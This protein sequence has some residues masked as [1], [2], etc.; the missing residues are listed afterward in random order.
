[1]GKQADLTGQRFGRLI[2]LRQN[3]IDKH[4]NYLWECKC[5][6]GEITYASGTSL[7]RGHKR[8]CGC[9]M[10]DEC[11]NRSRTHGLSRDRLYHAYYNI[12]QR[13][14]NPNSHAYE[15]YGGRGICVEWD[16][17]ESFRTWA[18]ENGY[19]EGLTLDRINVNGNYSP[20]NCRWITQAAQMRNTRKTRYLTYK[21]ET[22]PLIEWCEVLG[23]NF[24]TASGR[25]TKGWS[26]PQEI[27]FG[28]KPKVGG[29]YG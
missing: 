16:D 2:V 6:C 18:L 5:D 14:E 7:R 26:D 11:G 17:W 10:R 1:M 21:G 15:Y 13:C 29:V 12:K 22:K 4:H 23:V 8:S 24:N 20:D 3:G 25:V 9:L 19:K 27:L 28:R